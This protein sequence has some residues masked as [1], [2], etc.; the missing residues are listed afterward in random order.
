MENI[1]EL[2]GIHGFEVFIAAFEFLEGLDGGL[3]HAFVGLGGAAD[4]DKFIA[5]GEAFVAV[6]V[7]EPD[8]EQTRAGGGGFG[9]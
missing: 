3:G 7:I 9:L 8:T 4:E 1:G 2:A 6:G 5:G